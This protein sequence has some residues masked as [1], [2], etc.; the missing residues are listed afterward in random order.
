MQK[1]MAIE[2]KLQSIA[3]KQA[4]AQALRERLAFSVKIQ[5]ILPTAFDGEG[6][7]SLLP[8]MH[9]NRTVFGP[10]A[11]PIDCRLTDAAGND[12]M[13]T[14]QQ[15]LTLFPDDWDARTQERMH[16]MWLTKPNKEH[17]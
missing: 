5:A 6:K 9:K 7:V 14:A 17:E 2:D 4:Q 10:K 8:T 3:D 13:L 15:Y 12:H 11:F 16:R 1:Q